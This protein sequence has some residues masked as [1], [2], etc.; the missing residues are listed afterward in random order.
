[1]YRFAPFFSIL[2]ILVSTTAF[3]QFDI[4]ADVGLNKDIFYPP[5]QV[6]IWVR[7]ANPGLEEAV[8]VYLSV[9]TPEGREL[10]APEFTE[11]A[12]PW[13]S[14]LVLPQ[15]FQIDWTSI[16]EFR[17]PSMS[18]P[19]AAPGQYMASLWLCKAG[20][21]DRITLG[22]S[23]QFTIAPC[24]RKSWV[25]EN[26]IYD[27]MLDADGLWVGTPSGVELISNDGTFRSTFRSEDGAR[28]IN[29]LLFRG[30]DGNLVT[31][32]RSA[33][34]SIW[35]SY[36]WRTVLDE[37]GSPNYVD[38]LR[39][40][41]TDAEGTIW[42]CHGYSGSGVTQDV[43]QLT[44]YWPDGHTENCAPLISGLVQHLCLTGS[45]QACMVSTDGLHVFNGSSF[46]SFPV[47]EL[48]TTST[49]VV[50]SVH[51]DIRDNVWASVLFLSDARYRLLRY[52]LNSGERTWY[53]YE[54]PGLL[55]PLVI[56]MT[57]DPA[58][59][60][61]F[62]TY[63]GVSTFDGQSFVSFEAPFT[64][65]TLAVGFDGEIYA[66]TY[67]AG[68]H[69]FKDGMWLD[70]SKH[71]P[72][73]SYGYY[74]FALGL[75][76]GRAYI[77]RSVGG[78]PIYGIELLEEDGSVVL[79]DENLPALL[80]GVSQGKDGLWAWLTS[81]VYRQT[82]T[83]WENS[84]KGCIDWSTCGYIMVV[85]EDKQG[86]P[87]LLTLRSLWAYEEGTW[88]TVETPP[89]E[90]FDHVGMLIDSE[91]R[92]YLYSD[93]SGFDVRDPDGNWS[94]IDTSNL[95]P[96]EPHISGLSDDDVLYVCGKHS[97]RGAYLCLIDH[98]EA[99][100]FWLEDA[101][102]PTE[103]IDCLV[104]DLAGRAWM[105]TRD[106][107]G[108][109]RMIIYDRSTDTFKD[110][111]RESRMLPRDNEGNVAL[112]N[113]TI[114]RSMRDFGVYWSLGTYTPTRINLAP[115]TEILLD[116]EA[117]SP[118]DTMRVDA[119]FANQAGSVPIDWYAGVEDESGNLFYWPTFTK[120]KTP[121]FEGLL[122]PTDLGLILQLDNIV[123]PD[124]VPPGHYKWKTGFTRAGQDLW[125]GL[126]F[127][128]TCEF[129]IADD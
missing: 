23:Q 44:R 104:F 34:L 90:S 33:G 125:L 73:V 55:L 121:A 45:G 103:E 21:Q 106:P 26:Y 80:Y 57:S 109:E 46:D 6:E 58:G 123:I 66:G 76:E 1:M 117:Y 102:Y 53:D 129:D 52:D 110:I 119:Y 43:A 79:A 107:N 49:V 82:E 22:S 25:S 8:D 99:T 35:E 20:T 120:S 85:Q 68:L 112:M 54:T 111:P 31:G 95:L 12:H 28:S 51:A 30:F 113:K 19:L 61:W 126:G 116:K 67:G 4:F 39:S 86:T 101:G 63:G 65:D 9:A 29:S 56:D 89:R 69:V 10:Y 91:N 27:L 94:T 114:E 13:I 96:G 11:M 74:S 36:G 47:P 16:Y 83:G 108:R 18:F 92:L 128:E 97:E 42:L 3:A 40:A 38:R 59:N 100:N 77:A 118:G 50:Q 98:G 2:V 122:V 87:L 32:G 81:E 62:G 93:Y 7:G 37:P 15:G 48:T 71:E 14:G 64:V 17:L 88:A 124:D 24:D 78:S 105:V 5:D 72:E 127:T 115:R 60:V 75:P 41:A 84:T 70:Y